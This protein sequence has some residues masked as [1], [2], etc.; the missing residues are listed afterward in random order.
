MKK[1]FRYI[2]IICS[3][4]LYS[5]SDYL[6]IVPDNV[7]TLDIVFNNRNTAEKY[8]ANCYSFVPEYGSIW[9]NPGMSCGHECWY[10]TA[11]DA[12]FSNTT[13]FSIARGLQNTTVPYTDYWD[14]ERGAKPMFRAIRECNIFLEYVRDLHRVNDLT[15]SERKR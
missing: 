5:C 4:L 1:K 6:D 11:E 15:D 3:T 10:Y 13:S 8:L 12:R 9:D 14:G 2:I 7:A